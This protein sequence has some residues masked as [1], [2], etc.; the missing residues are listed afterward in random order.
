MARFDEDHHADRWRPG[1]AVLLSAFLLA[2]TSGGVIAAGGG[3]PHDEGSASK[4]E[5][6]PPACEP[7]RHHNEGNRHR[8]KP[9]PEREIEGHKLS[10]QG[11][12]GCK[13]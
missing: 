7:H 6:K 11:L 10:A 13:G 5:Y 12:E 9:S 2:A 8:F 3:P 1:L 4:A